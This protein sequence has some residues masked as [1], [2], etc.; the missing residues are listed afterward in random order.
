MTRLSAAYGVEAGLGG[1]RVGLLRR[2]GRELAGEAADGLAE[3]GGSAEGVALPERQPAGDAGRRRD[4]HP[5]V[6]DVLDPPAGRAEREDVADPG[7]VD[8]LLVELADPPAGALADEEDP[9]QPAVGDG[10]AARDGEPL[11][12][13]AAGDGAADAVPDDAGAELGELVGGVPPAEQV[14]GRLEGAA[15]EGGERCAA[16]YEVVE[17]VDRPR[18]EGGG[19]DDLLGEHVER[20]GRDAHRLDG[21]GAHPLDGHGGLGEV[22]AVLGEEHAARHLADL[23]AGAADAL[24]GA[25]DAGRGLDLD[26]EV[27]R[28]HVD[29]ELEA[30]G[31]DDAG[32][33]AALEVVLDD[34][35][36][37]LGDRAV[38]GL[39]DDDL[40][41]GARSGLGHDL[42]RL[43]AGLRQ[44]AAGPV[45][46]DLV[47]ARGQPLGEAAGVGEDDGGAVLL[48][49]VDDVLLDVRPDR[50]AA[51][52]V[53]VVVGLDL[54][55]VGCRHVLD[56]DD[57]LEVPGLVGRRGHDVDGRVAAEEPGDLVERPYGRGEADP[58]GGLLEER[59][60]ALEADGQVGA[61]LAS[62]DGVHLVDDDGVDTAEGLARLRGQHQEQR[63]GRG[64]E[65]VGR[66]AGQPAPLLGGGVTGPDADAD[67]GQLGALRAGRRCGGCR[68]AARAGC[69]RRRPPAP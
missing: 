8:H 37:L 27:D 36:L 35:P 34:R 62:G 20:V 16:A 13:G 7:L 64:D 22:A 59:V 21:A 14:E 2:E 66:L 43:L 15:G 49:E 63:L 47:E 38:V 10:A 25:G 6:G 40:G 17:V 54:V 53:G 55:A 31:G 23:V 48:D 60:E 33:A 19:G 1:A 29:A 28:A 18:L 67:L 41:S 11:R 39:G 68:P 45:G 5:V 65:D 32:E 69:A 56:G 42:G 46:G 52:V 51:A 3:L 9:E 58:L 50:A 61:A 57:H 24:E 44:V 30:A 26:D 4:Q 12:A